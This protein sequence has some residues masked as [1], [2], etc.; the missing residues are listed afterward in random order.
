MSD[1]TI[2]IALLGLFTYLTSYISQLK[3]E[4]R[5]TNL[6]LNKIVKHLGIEEKI[7]DNIDYELKNII[8][9]SGKIKAIKRYREITGKGLKES[10]EYVDSLIERN[11]V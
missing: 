6:T 10:K 2:F 1:I 8:L 11:G 4:L 5:R 3:D 9:E 7:I